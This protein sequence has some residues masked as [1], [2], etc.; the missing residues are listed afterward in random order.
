MTESSQAAETIDRAIPPATSPAAVVPPPVP[1]SEAKRVA[2][3]AVSDPSAEQLVEPDPRSE[4]WLHAPSWLTSMVAHLTLV[5]LLALVSNAQRIYEPSRDVDVSAQPGSDAGTGLED[6][7]SPSMEL[8]QPLQTSELTQA[9]PQAVDLFGPI[10][11]DSLKVDL[12]AMN[13]VAGTGGSA[14][15]E[16]AGGAGSG[17]AIGNS[18]EMRLNGNNRAAMV[19]RGGGTP[20]SEYAVEQALR[21]LADPDSCCRSRRPRLPETPVTRMVGFAVSI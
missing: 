2:T 16:G 19:K 11:V 3:A 12:G 6:L 20:E 21:W 13:V 9:G 17:D 4:L 10:P 18:L 5:L 15:G 1:P 7:P 8:S 14:I